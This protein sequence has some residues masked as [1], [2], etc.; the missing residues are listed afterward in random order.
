MP[1]LAISFLQSYD[2]M[3]DAILQL[4]GRRVRL[5]GAHDEHTSVTHVVWFSAEQPGR[6][7]GVMSTDADPTMLGFGVKANSKHKIE[8]VGGSD[9][10]KLV[11]IMTC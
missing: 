5:R 10:F 8:L 11:S 3:G 1:T 2:G 7:D 4:N 6:T 9:K